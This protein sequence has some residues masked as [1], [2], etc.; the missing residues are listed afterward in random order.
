MSSVPLRSYHPIPYFPSKLGDY[1]VLPFPKNCIYCEKADGSNTGNCKVCDGTGQQREELELRLV[2]CSVCNGT[3]AILSL[4]PCELCNKQGMVYR[5]S[6][7]NINAN[8][9]RDR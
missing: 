4:Y 3:G 6:N 8:G 2:L 7:D 1:T 9:R 5:W